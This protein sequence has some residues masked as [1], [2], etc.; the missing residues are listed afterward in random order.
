MAEPL[1]AARARLDEALA[2]FRRAADEAIALA[3]K[4]R[5]DVVSLAHARTRA[6]FALAATGKAF[7]D[8]LEAARPG[9]DELGRDVPPPPR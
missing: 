1:D 2:V 7:K 4:P 6:T 3:A 5:L 8:A 9:I